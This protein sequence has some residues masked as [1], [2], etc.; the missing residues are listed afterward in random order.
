MFPSGQVAI[1]RYRTAPSRRIEAR[2]LAMLQNV[3]RLLEAGS[4]YADFG[5]AR[6]PERLALRAMHTVY[7]VLPTDPRRWHRGVA[8]LAADYAV[9]IE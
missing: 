2:P 3:G 5:N 1:P 8:A 7:G 4:A 6:L 9:E